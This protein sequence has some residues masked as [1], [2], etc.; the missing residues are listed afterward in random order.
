[1]S[2]NK[3][4]TKTINRTNIKNKKI[5][6]SS[7]FYFKSHLIIILCVL[8]LPLWAFGSNDFDNALKF[9]ISKIQEKF[10]PYLVSLKKGNAVYFSKNVALAPLSIIEESTKTIAVDSKLKIALLTVD[11]FLKEMEFK[12]PQEN[13]DVFF[14]LTNNGFIKI[15]NVR[16]I[17]AGNL[18]KLKGTYSFGSLLISTDLEPLG[19]IVSSDEESSEVLL[20]KAVEKEIEKLIN[21]KPGWLGIQAQTI[22]EDL[23]RV[24]SSDYGVVITNIYQNGPADKVGLKRG[25]IIIEADNVTIKEFKDLQDLLSIKFSGEVMTVKVR[26]NETKKEFTVTLEE[27][28][29]LIKQ[30]EIQLPSIPG[31]EIIEIPKNVKESIKESIKGV[32]INNVMENSP[33]LGILK[34]GDIIVELNKYGINNTQDFYEIISRSKGDLL[35]LL[36]RQGNFQYVII[37]SQKSR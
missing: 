22:T 29:E 10:S 35:I 15:F 2:T 24:L 6:T 5:H 12:I 13:S 28:P 37:P 23:K 16:G 30:A 17:K 31:V 3:S 9:K 25:D 36:Y 7:N 34:K 32:Y 27:P 21:R 11:K 26:R 18:I 19:I 20:I 14:L 8:F 1:M 33:V 4:N